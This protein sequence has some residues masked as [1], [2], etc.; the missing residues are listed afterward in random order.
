MTL[1]VTSTP[2][3]LPLTSPILVTDCVRVAPT[4]GIIVEED[5]DYLVEFTASILVASAT[6]GLSVYADSK[7][8]GNAGSLSAVGLANFAEI[9]HLCKGDLVQVVANG[10]IAAGVLGQGTLTVAKLDEDCD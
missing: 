1:A 10:P 5:G 7:F 3:P 9:V 2:I 4:G 8:L 6:G